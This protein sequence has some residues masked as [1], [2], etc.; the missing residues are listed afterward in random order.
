MMSPDHDKERWG[1]RRQG[2]VGPVQR[3]QRRK[4]KEGERWAR[5][6][7]WNVGPVLFS[8]CLLLFGLSSLGPIF[9][10]FVHFSKFSNPYKINKNILKFEVNNLFL[11]NIR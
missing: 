10:N 2:T 11:A 5:L 4:G 8:F 9:G 7:S 1:K 3:K 6:A